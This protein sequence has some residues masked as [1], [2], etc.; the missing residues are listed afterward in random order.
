MVEADGAFK[1]RFNPVMDRYA[2]D[3]PVDGAA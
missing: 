2:V 1:A 3:L